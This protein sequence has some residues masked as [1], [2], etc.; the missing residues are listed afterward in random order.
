MATKFRPLTQHLASR[1]A[2]A[3]HNAD[4]GSIAVGSIPTILVAEHKFPAFCAQLKIKKM[5]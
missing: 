2:H 1:M 5:K 4:R 3:R